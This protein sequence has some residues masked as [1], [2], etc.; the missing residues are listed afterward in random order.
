[1]KEIDRAGFHGQYDFLYLPMRNS[2]NRGFVFVNF[3]YADIA[4]RF[5]WRFHGQM[6]PHTKMEKP[7]AVMPADVQGLEQN[8]AHYMTR[9]QQKIRPKAVFPQAKR[10]QHGITKE[11]PVMLPQMPVCVVPCIAASDYADQYNSISW[12]GIPMMTMQ[13]N[14]VCASPSTAGIPVP[15]F[16]SNCGNSRNLSHKFCPFCAVSFD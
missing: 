2:M 6:S 15:S 9:S 4:E 7:F 5:Y 16:C 12:A 13:P 14:V 10:R 11:P 1:M 3:M 8:M